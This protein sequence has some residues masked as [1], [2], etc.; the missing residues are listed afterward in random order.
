MEQEKTKATGRKSKKKKVS[1]KKPI[2]PTNPNGAGAP[3][4]LN[5]ELIDQICQYILGGSY[6]ETASAA[7]GV[8]KETFYQ[9]LKKGKQDI[10]AL[11]YLTLEAKL[12]QRVLEALGKADVRDVMRIDKAAEQDWRAAAW[13]LE[14]RNAK[15]WGPKAAIKVEDGDKEGFTDSENIHKALAEVVSAHEEAED[16][17]NETP[18]GIPNQGAE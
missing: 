17:A 5:E 9:W 16:G 2:T 3:K 4:K 11:N 18:I 8:S 14:R 6:V 1:K 15:H 12:S 13:R 10:N 7:C